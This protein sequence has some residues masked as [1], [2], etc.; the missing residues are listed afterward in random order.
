MSIRV[1]VKPAKEPHLA[2]HWIA[3][4]GGRVETGTSKLAA[5]GA[6]FVCIPE[7]AARRFVS[8]PDLTSPS[9]GSYTVHLYGDVTRYSH[10]KNE[11]EA[12]GRFVC[13]HRAA[14]DV[15]VEVD[16]FEVPVVETILDDITTKPND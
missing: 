16:N 7:I 3:E 2:G 8:E 12:I 4:S 6:L 11:Y 13:H 15:V 9:K 14:L 5:L 1:I 10:G